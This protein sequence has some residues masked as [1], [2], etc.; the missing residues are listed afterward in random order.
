MPACRLRLRLRFHFQLRYA[1]RH[2]TL[3]AAAF[4]AKAPPLTLPFAA[5]M[6]LPCYAMML[7]RHYARDDDYYYRLT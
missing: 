2:F 7:L 3:L 1:I 5:A 6:L 4:D